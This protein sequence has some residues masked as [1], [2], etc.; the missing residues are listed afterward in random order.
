MDSIGY[1]KNQLLPISEKEMGILKKLKQNQ[2][3]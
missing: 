2:P 1:T 3:K